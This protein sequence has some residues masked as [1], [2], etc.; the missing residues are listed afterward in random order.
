MKIPKTV[1]VRGREWR[2]VFRKLKGVEG[3]CEHGRRRISI[4][5]DLPERH[6]A[7]VFLHELLHACLP[8]MT[9]GPDAEEAMVLRLAPRLLRAMRSLGWVTGGNS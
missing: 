6:H 5:K 1:T 8:E 9:P 3:L 2:V 4:S 7:E